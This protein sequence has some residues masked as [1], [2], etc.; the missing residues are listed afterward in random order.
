MLELQPLYDR[1]ADSGRAWCVHE[2]KMA[3]QQMPCNG[4][5]P[6]PLSSV[7]SGETNSNGAL[8]FKTMAVD[9]AMLRQ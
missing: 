8:S 2:A 5:A 6:A 9:P 1:P 4:M 7:L 3:L